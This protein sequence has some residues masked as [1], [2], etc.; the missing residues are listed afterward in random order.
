MNRGKICAAGLTRF[1]CV[2]L[3][4]GALPLIAWAETVRVADVIDGDTLRLS[5][6]R[7]LRL[8]G[9]DAPELGH[10]REVDQFYAR[11]AREALRQLV[12]GKSLTLRPV[13]QG[14]KDRH[15]RVLAEALLP[16]GTSVNETLLREGAATA[17]W[18]K[19]LDEAFWQ[20]MYAAQSTAL[21][22]KVGL[23]EKLL[24]HPV[25]AHAY[26]GNRNSRRF[27][28]ENCQEARQIHA[29]NR[30]LFA[31]V[32]AAFAAGFAP[33]RVCVFWPQE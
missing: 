24:R 12:R 9:L 13:S 18:H 4:L 20:R 6:G 1:F 32:R 11:E 19:D 8:A 7:S 21:R 14:G 3:L 17:Y 22:Q 25:A 15:K 23:W 5:D 31:D 33:A 28:P 27:F 26:V 2:C 30:V 16:D 29:R 10:G